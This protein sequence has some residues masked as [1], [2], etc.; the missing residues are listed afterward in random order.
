MRLAHALERS[1][2]LAIRLPTFLWS[3]FLLYFSLPIFSFTFH[4]RWLSWKQ[5]GDVLGWAHG[6]KAFYGFK[7]LQVHPERRLFT[8]KCIYLCNHRSWADFMVDQY[9]TQGR[10]LFM[11]RWAVAYVFPLFMVPMWFVRAVLLFKRGSIADKVAFNAW[12]DREWEKSTQTALGVYPE[13]HRSTTGESLPLK[14]GMLHYAFDRKIPV[15]V[16]I[17]ANKEHIL[18][19]KKM[20]VGFGRTVKVGYSEVLFPER[21][22]DF[23]SFMSAVQS[24]WDSEWLEVMGADDAHDAHLPELEEPVPYRDTDPVNFFKLLLICPAEVAFFAYLMRWWIKVVLGGLWTWTAPYSA[25]VFG[26]LSAWILTS[27]G[28]ALW[29]R[30]TTSRKQR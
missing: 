1:A 23:Q 2:T 21:F 24:T 17:G 11:S 10:T 4:L 12:I 5:R 3:L 27:F 14:R 25:V 28:N 16:V 29:W 13:G 9:V 15:Q 6:M 26:A 8:G 22:S 7:V 18:S 19:E 20:I 30:E